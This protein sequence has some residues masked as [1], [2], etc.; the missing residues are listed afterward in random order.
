VDRIDF[1]VNMSAGINKIRTLL[2]GAEASSTG[3]LIQG[4]L[5][6]YFSENYVKNVGENFGENCG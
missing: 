6:N 3:V 4:F 1:V 5:Y 2:R